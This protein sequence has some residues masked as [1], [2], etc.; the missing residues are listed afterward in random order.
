MMHTRKRIAV[1]CGDTSSTIAFINV[2]IK[3]SPKM[4]NKITNKKSNVY[5]PFEK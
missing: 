5:I 3:L 4:K 1:R 2:H